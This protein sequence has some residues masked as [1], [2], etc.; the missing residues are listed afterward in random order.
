[1]PT[2]NESTIEVRHGF[3][4]LTELNGFSVYVKG[5]AIRTL[6]SDRERDIGCVVCFADLDKLWVKENVLDILDAVSR[7]YKQVTGR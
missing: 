2:F 7:S 1:M 4:L 5:S 3:L 6:Y